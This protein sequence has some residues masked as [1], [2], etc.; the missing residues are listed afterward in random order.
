MRR[1][2]AAL[3]LLALLFGG[4]VYYPT[5]PDIG[6]VRIRP[7]NA[8]AVPHATGFAVYLDLDSTG[9]YGDALVGA[10]TDIA[11]RAAL[12]VPAGQ[13]PNRVV[14]PAAT[15]VRFTPQGPHI[16]L[17]DLTRAVAPGEVVLVTLLF[18]K[19]GRI[20]VPTRFE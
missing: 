3:L 14:V 5:I 19:L 11:R 1:G 20:G 4:C 9:G 6:G 8:R 13:P 16:V 7:Q 17:S 18:E 10:T 12:V 15:L 2:A